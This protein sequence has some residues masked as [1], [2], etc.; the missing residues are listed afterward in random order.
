MIQMS[1]IIH[2]FVKIG[3]PLGGLLIIYIKMEKITLQRNMDDGYGTVYCIQ[4]QDFELGNIHEYFGVNDEFTDVDSV[5]NYLQE[6]YEQDDYDFIEDAKCNLD[7][8][9]DAEHF[10]SIANPNGSGNNVDNLVLIYNGK[11]LFET[12]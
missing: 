9:E 1:K 7:D 8:S 6:R 12:F 2:T 11:V 5:V 10:Q 4:K 3:V